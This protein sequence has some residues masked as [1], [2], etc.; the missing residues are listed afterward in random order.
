MQSLCAFPKLFL[1]FGSSPKSAERNKG[2]FFW[3]CMSVLG[4]GWCSRGGYAARRRMSGLPMWSTNTLLQGFRQE[5][6]NNQGKYKKR[7]F[8][9]SIYVINVNLHCCKLWRISCLVTARYKIKFIIIISCCSY[10]FKEH[11]CVIG[12]QHCTSGTRELGELHFS[13]CHPS[14]LWVSLCLSF[15][16]FKWSKS[17]L[18]A[19]R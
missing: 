3:D 12:E 6:G 4:S 5:N 16:A 7:L 19:L 8:Y 9:N 2:V 13:S 18:G 17:F 15:L 14:G 10:F 1:S 11:T